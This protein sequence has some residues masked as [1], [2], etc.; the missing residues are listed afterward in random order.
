MTIPKFEITPCFIG[1]VIPEEFVVGIRDLWFENKMS[2][3][4]NICPI[5]LITV[6]NELEISHWGCIHLANTLEFKKI[7]I[8]VKKQQ[9][10]GK[11]FI[12][13][14]ETV[15]CWKNI[16]IK[17]N[18]RLADR[19]LQEETKSYQDFLN[20]NAAFKSLNI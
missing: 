15:A 11:S 20:R 4:F 10:E 3:E 7:E 8:F 6:G 1:I 2:N 13:K 12:E 19:S 16:L 9:L 14:G 5:P 17:L 18:L